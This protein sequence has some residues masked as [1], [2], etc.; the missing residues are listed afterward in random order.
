MADSTFTGVFLPLIVIAVML[1]FS[2]KEAPGWARILDLANQESKREHP[3][4]SAFPAMIV[5]ISLAVAAITFLA[6]IPFN[7]TDRG[8][9]AGFGVALL[10]LSTIIITLSRWIKRHA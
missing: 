1:F 6:L 5:G 9:L 3:A 7:D 2:R 4:S 8:L 10:V